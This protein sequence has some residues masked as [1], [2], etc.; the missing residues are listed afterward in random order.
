MGSEEVGRNHDRVVCQREE[1]E[2]GGSGSW[3]GGSDC[4]RGVGKGHG[5]VDRVRGTAVDAK[6]EARV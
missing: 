5:R 3:V 4:C 6:S 2:G 1:A